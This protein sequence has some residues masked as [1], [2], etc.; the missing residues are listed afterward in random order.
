M[1]TGHYTRIKGRMTY[2]R[3]KIPELLQ[4]RLSSTEI[5]YRL[6]VISSRLAERLGRRLAAEVDDFF[7]RATID[8]MLNSADLTR[9]VQTAIAAWRAD[10]AVEAALDIQSYGRPLLHPKE[11][12]PPGLSWLRALFGRSVTVKARMAPHSFPKWLKRLV[13]LLATTKS[14]SQPAV[15][16]SAWG[17]PRTIC[18]QPWR[19]RPCMVWE[20][21]PLGTISLR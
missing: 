8:P 21:S 9:L 4:K 20:V 12:Q 10:D 19:R 6:G 18:N 15:V 2:F 7:E 13:S 11:Q 3:R 5:C 16:R 14:S 17:W 1:R